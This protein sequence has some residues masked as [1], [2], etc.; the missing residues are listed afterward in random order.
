M[1]ATVIVRLADRGANQACG[2]IAGKI[3]HGQRAAIGTAGLA[4]CQQRRKDGHRRVAYVDVDIVEVEG[5]RSRAVDQR[6]LEH[7]HLVGVS[8]D[9]SHAATAVE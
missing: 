9:R 6:R 2:L 8:D 4:Q 7:C 1:E 3:R 5:V